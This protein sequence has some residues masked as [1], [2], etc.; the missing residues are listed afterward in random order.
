MSQM[1]V[2]LHVDQLIRA[3]EKAADA[4][5]DDI[6]ADAALRARVDI[7]ARRLFVHQ[8]SNEWDRIERARG[9]NA[10]RVWRP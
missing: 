8:P 1:G 5:L 4:F 10:A 2:V 9:R 7:R 3:Y 6:E